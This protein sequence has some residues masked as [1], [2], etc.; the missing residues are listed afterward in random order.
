ML[1]EITN[2]INQLPDE[3]KLMLRTKF[4][5]EWLSP[6]A[7]KIAQILTKMKEDDVKTVL[8]PVNNNTDGLQTQL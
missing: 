6:E 4:L 7:I 3:D 5:N 1:E 2:L 8:A